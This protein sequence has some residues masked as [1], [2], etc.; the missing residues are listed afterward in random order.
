MKS[1]EYRESACLPSERRFCYSVLC[2]A[3][4]R[5]N[6]A[7]WF[8]RHSQSS[9]R[10][11]TSLCTL[12]EPGPPRKK[13]EFLCQTSANG[14]IV[15][16][17]WLPLPER[18]IVHTETQLDYFPSPPTYNRPGAHHHYTNTREARTKTDLRESQES[19]V[20]RAACLWRCAGKAQ[21]IHTHTHRYITCM[22]SMGHGQKSRS[23]KAHGARGARG[24]RPE[25][26]DASI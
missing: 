6:F 1:S 18:F 4:S 9:E 22:R 5:A 12:R 11:E 15:R 25:T 13:D 17:R 2:V 24:A 14:T 20:A 16:L 3:H 26:R 19:T 7:F 10:T 8:L 23:G 21:Q